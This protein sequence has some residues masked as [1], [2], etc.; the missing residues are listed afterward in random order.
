MQIGYS[1]TKLWTHGYIRAVLLCPFLF[2]RSP[3]QPSRN[4]FQRRVHKILLCVCVGLWLSCS[5]RQKYMVSKMMGHELR[6]QFVKVIT[7]MINFMNVPWVLLSS[8]LMMMST[9][10]TIFSN[11]LSKIL[12]LTINEQSTYMQAKVWMNNVAKLHME[13]PELAS[14]SQSPSLWAPTGLPLVATMARNRNGEGNLKCLLAS[15]PCDWQTWE[16]LSSQWWILQ[17]CYLSI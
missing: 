11:V 2:L 5:L 15:S 1:Y 17:P 4:Y 10:S 7:H 12:T 6:F 3:V 9:H 13:A 16:H 8:F 14:H